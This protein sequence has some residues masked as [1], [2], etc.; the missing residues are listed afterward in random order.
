MS[1]PAGSVRTLRRQRKRASA[2][3]Q[4]ARR[5]HSTLWRWQLVRWLARA[6]S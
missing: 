5:Q 3:P 1:E 2:S 6:E 4:R